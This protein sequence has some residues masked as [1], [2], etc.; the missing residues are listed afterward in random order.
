M[1]SAGSKK[2]IFAAL[3]GNALIAATKFAASAYTGSSAMLSEA[4]HSLVDTGNQGLLLYGLKRAARPAD[5][6]H[7]FGYGPELYFWA[8]VVAILIF[9]LGAG[10]SL[11]E[12]VTKIIEP[13]P[14]TNAF[15][16]YIVLGVA[17]VFEA[18]A[19]AIALKEFRAI[20]GD[21]GYLE[22]V[23]QSKDPAL[24]TVLFEDSAALLGLIVAALGIALGQFFDLPVMDGVA[25]V[26][27]GLILGLTAIL[28]A[29]ECKGLLI[30]EG[31]RPELVVGIRQIALGTKGILAVNELRT[32]HLGPTDVLVNISIDFADGLDSGE[33]EAVV[34]TMERQVK[35]VFPDVSRIFIEAQGRGG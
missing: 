5:A 1:A 30:G 20:K 34:S 16:N 2:V 9:A 29:Y 23:R 22:A 19:W 13:H 18:G 10:I 4:I 35:E 8:F 26:G 21:Q 12:G 27:I 25:S 28:L 31:A 33:V 3:A 14:V 24:F 7:P 17:F 6:K 15:I 11:Y 32:M